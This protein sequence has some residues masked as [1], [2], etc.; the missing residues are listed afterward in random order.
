M[1]SGMSGSI[2]SILETTLFG[3]GSHNEGS[4]PEMRIWSMLLIKS[5]LKWC[6]H[7]SRSLFLYFI[8]FI[9]HFGLNRKGKKLLIAK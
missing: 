3:E 9:G 7:L 4:L 1:K 8:A 2:F 6:I 5:E